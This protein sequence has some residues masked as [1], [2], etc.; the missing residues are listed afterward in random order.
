MAKWV[1]RTANVVYQMSYPWMLTPSIFYPT[2][3]SY[4][5]HLCQRFFMKNFFIQNCFY[6]L[7]NILSWKKNVSTNDLCYKR[8][9]NRRFISIEFT[10]RARKFKKSPGKKLVKSNIYQ[11]HE[12]NFFEYFPWKLKFYFQ[13]IPRKIPCNWFILFH[14][15]FGLDFLKFSGPHCGIGYFYSDFKAIIIPCFW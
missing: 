1:V 4:I 13:K 6:F 12:K 11:F 2:L 7:K 15:F 10:A 8:F 5:F 14:E 9:Q 3:E